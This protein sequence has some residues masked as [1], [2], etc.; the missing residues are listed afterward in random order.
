MGFDASTSVPR[1][2][3]AACRR[4]RKKLTYKEVYLFSKYFSPHNFIFANGLENGKLSVG[5]EA[6]DFEAE[7]G[8]DDIYR[9]R[10]RND[11]KWPL[12]PSRSGLT[13]LAPGK[14]RHSHLH[15]GNDG[16]FS[17][18]SGLRTFLT[19]LPGAAFG[20]CGKQWLFQFRQ[21]SDMQFFGMGE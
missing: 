17:L 13:P 2:P 1:G 11:A 5:D 6:F 10:I 4:G 21:H 14:G 9:I 20:I 19:T 15:V 8:S 16:G 7:G 12:Q 18:R 3:A